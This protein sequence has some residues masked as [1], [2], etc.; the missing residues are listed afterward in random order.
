MKHTFVAVQVQI[1][2][3]VSTGQHECNS[4]IDVAKPTCLQLPLTIANADLGIVCQTSDID[5]PLFHIALLSIIVLIQQTC[6]HIRPF[7]WATERSSLNVAREA[8]D[9][10]RHSATLHDTMNVTLTRE[11]ARELQRLRLGKKMAPE[12]VVSGTHLTKRSY[13]RWENGRV[14]SIRERNLRPILER[15]GTTISEFLGDE[16]R[17]RP[18]RGLSEPS[19]IPEDFDQ[20][21]TPLE[22]LSVSEQV[23]RSLISVLQ[24]ERASLQKAEVYRDLLYGGLAR[25]DF[26]VSVFTKCI[27]KIERKD[28]LPRVVLD[29]DANLR[30]LQILLDDVVVLEIEKPLLLWDCSCLPNELSRVLKRR[31]HNLSRCTIHSH[32]GAVELMDLTSREFVELR[33][34]NV[35]ILWRQ[36]MQLWPPSIDSVLTY[37]NL[38]MAGVL[39][40]GA[41]SILDLGCGT[42]VLGVSLARNNPSVRRVGFADWLLTPLL[43]S[44]LNAKHNL[45]SLQLKWQMHLGMFDDWIG[46]PS[47]VPYDL[48]V[49]TPPYLPQAKGFDSVWAESPV[50]GTELLNFLLCNRIAKNTYVTI[51][52]LVHDEAKRAAKEHHVS[53]EAIGNP[54]AVP[55][56]VPA[57]L[58]STTYITSLLDSGRLKFRPKNRYPLWHRIMTFKLT[59]KLT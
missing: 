43:C 53:M 32:P 42:G 18:Q 7:V 47:A 6:R 15:L 52:T 59:F 9:L 33:F 30:R 4:F 13:E 26:S 12:D 22:L 56:R 5:D 3:P 27:E 17:V 49:C 46:A 8:R 23:D 41:E 36:S 50:G 57:A 48:L 39:E 21:K 1:C 11:R 16:R 40:T 2:P 44:T 35:S 25:R 28:C 58:R 38:Q 31:G 10:S 19:Q 20:T 34:Q 51:S 54:V 29:L 55:F 24:A 37:R 45:G 14:D